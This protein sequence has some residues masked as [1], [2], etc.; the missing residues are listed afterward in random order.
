MFSQSVKLPET[1]FNFRNNQS[2]KTSLE[3][4]PAPN[5]VRHLMRSPPNAVP[6]IFRM[7]FRLD[8]LSSVAL[9]LTQI[10]FDLTFMLLYS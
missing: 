2:K 1:V 6:T 7:L 10:S 4:C 3:N 8:W 9:I 5:A